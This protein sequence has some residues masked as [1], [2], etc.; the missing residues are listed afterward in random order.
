MNE[1]DRLLIRLTEVKGVLRQSSVNFWKGN[2][3][4]LSLLLQL[5][6]QMIKMKFTE[7]ERKPIAEMIE[8][9]SKLKTALDDVIYIVS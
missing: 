2:N 6:N 8:A 1:Q 3:E 5:D 9:I 4:L 7:K